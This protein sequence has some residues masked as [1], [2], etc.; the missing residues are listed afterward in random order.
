MPFGYFLYSFGLGFLILV[1]YGIL[2][3]LHIP[4]GNLV[5]WLIGVASFWWLLF[6]VTIPWNIYF[7]AREV[8]AE[9]AASIEKGIT[10][11]EKQVKYVRLI[12]RWSLVGAVAL[13]I[14][15]A[16]GLYGLAYF[17]ISAVGYASSA[18]TLL[19]TGL[20][21]AIRG[22]QYLA[23]R[24]RMI[25]KEIKYPREDVLTLRSRVSA[26]ESDI[27]GLKAQV[28]TKAEAKTVLELQ[29]DSQE[30]R[31]KWAQLRASL[32]QLQANN[33]AEHQHIAIEAQNAIA[34]LSEDS[35]FLGQVREIVRFIKTA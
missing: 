27:K 29:Q 19:L 4:A 17:G 7:D 15:S 30:M 21:P 8:L 5:D 3:W 2:E 20:R 14:L 33:E 23:L 6:I 24:L 26:M 22:Y 25:R 13:H 16:L 12:A 31:Q 18:A 11:K 9:A 32:E 35:R 34:Q 1:I 28:T 10:V